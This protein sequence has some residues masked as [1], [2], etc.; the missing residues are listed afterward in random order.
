M[1]ITESGITVILH[2]PPAGFDPRTATSTELVRAGFPRRPDD[3]QHLAHWNRIL[4]ELNGKLNYTTP[5][6]GPARRRPEPR[7]QR[8]FPAG[9][10]SAILSDHWSGALV[11][12]PDGQSFYWLKADWTV[13][14]ITAPDPT[15]SYTVVTWIGIDGEDTDSELCQIGIEQ[16]IVVDGDSVTTQCY[17]WYGWWTEATPY[18]IPI[19]NFG[20]SPGD[21]VTL[22]LCTAGASS[23]K[24]TAWYAN[25]TT[26]QVTSLTF[27]AP[28]GTTLLGHCAEWVVERPWLNNEYALLPD[29][30]RVIF[31]ECTAGTGDSTTVNGGSGTMI[32]MTD[33]NNTVISAAAAVT[34]TEI[35]CEYTGPTAA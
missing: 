22:V 2:S 31:S 17:A 21:N 20:V 24:A 28:Q 33:G 30:N 12:P 18:I 23:T 29:Y 6:F 4:E 1:D 15:Q 19:S 13:P 11:V 26:R 16:A 9:T 32:D 3:P 25:T 10:P 27:T 8:A 7:L 34:S 5:A 14:T 35:E